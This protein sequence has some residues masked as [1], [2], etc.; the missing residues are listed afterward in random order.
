MSCFRRLF[1]VLQPYHHGQKVGG[2]E[3]QFFRAS[4]SFWRSY[5]SS[6]DGGGGGAAL[7]VKKKKKKE[8]DKTPN[9]QK[10]S[11]EVDKWRKDWRKPP[12]VSPPSTYTFRSHTCGQL[13]KE[14]EG[15]SVRLCGWLTFKR[16]NGTFVVLR[17]LYGVTQIY[18]P[19]ELE[20]AAKIACDAPLESVLLI[21]GKVALR[22]DH[23]RR[24]DQISGDIEVVATHISLLNTPSELRL[25]YNDLDNVEEEVAI[26][27]RHLYIRNP[28]SQSVLRRRALFLGNVRRFMDANHFIEVETPTLVRRT[29]GGAREFPVVTRVKN[30]YYALAQSPQI[31]K[32]LLMCGGMDKYYQI[33]RCYRDEGGKPDRQPEFTQ[34]DIEMS[35]TTREDVMRLVEDLLKYSLPEELL[36]KPLNS[37][38]P[39]MTYAECM[40]KYGS[41]K[42]DT[43]GFLWVVDFPLF[44]KGEESNRLE[45]AHHPFTMPRDVEE[46]YKS[47]EEKDFEAL[48]GLSY[49]LVYCGAEVGGGS[50]RIHDP[51]LQKHVFGKVLGL[52]LEEID[53]LLEGLESGAPP[54][55]GFALGVDRFLAKVMGTKSIRDVIAFPKTSQGKDALS[56]AP[57]ELEEDVKK[58]YG[59]K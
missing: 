57:T 28:R 58:Y 7:G 23:Q 52:K 38:F 17:D 59:I 12:P 4:S 18:V 36:P 35:F 48:V 39:I 13:T 24:S 47:K 49:D 3:K 6:A 54:H 53:Y 21:Q 29:P 20:N 2:F 10:L 46:L 44:L 19:K 42:P 33:A 55:G 16:L 32:Q 51:K 45:A 40:S 34:L 27:Y 31:L 43:G 14:D 30:A 8:E 5:S 22:P 25:A 37:P 26:H 1:F 56:G 15:K 41:D 50:I 11:E 9:I